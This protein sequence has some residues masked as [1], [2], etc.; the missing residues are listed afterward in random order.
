MRVSKET[1]T[2]T[3]VLIF[4]IINQLLTKKGYNPLPFS[5][6]ELYLIASDIILYGSALWAW[7]KNNSFSEPA[8]EADEYMKELKAKNKAIKV[9]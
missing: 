2:R 5:D 6:E 7:W 3:I 8:L 4:A 1:I 9:L